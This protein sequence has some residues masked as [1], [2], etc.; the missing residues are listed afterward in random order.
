M[1]KGYKLKSE[2]SEKQIEA[3]V[4]TYLGWISAPGKLPFRLLDIDEQLTGADK[5]LNMVIPI[6]MQFKVSQGLKPLNSPLKIPFFNLDPLQRIRRFRKDLE[7]SDNPSL[8]FK[9][10]DMANGATEF[11]HNILMKLNSSGNS[12]GFYVSPLT[13]KKKEYSELLYASSDRFLYY[14][15][16]DRTTAVYQR[17]WMSY[18]GLVPFLRGHI[19][20]MPHEKVQTSN[21]YYSFS[22]TGSEIGWHSPQFFDT[23]SRLSDRLRYILSAAF[24]S[25]NAWEYI[26]NYATEMRSNID[27]IPSDMVPANNNLPP[28]EQIR[29]LGRIIYSLFSIRQILLLA[30]GEVL[31]SVLVSQ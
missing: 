26:E 9:L 23:A 5:N 11:Q 21:H 24:R 29:Q 25:L 13:L 28:L 1:L 20:I 16:I 2:L 31:K 7:L 27:F 18:L 14:P 4:A 22:Q 30:D 6:Y 19:S 3:D 10:R 8:Y 12:L 17:G 15:F